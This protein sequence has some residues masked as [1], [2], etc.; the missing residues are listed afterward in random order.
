MIWCFMSFS[1]VFKSY[2]SIERMKWK[3]LCDEAKKT[4]LNDTADKRKT[5]KLSDHETRSVS[6]KN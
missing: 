2:Q 3:A 1:T 5:A 4:E 6:L